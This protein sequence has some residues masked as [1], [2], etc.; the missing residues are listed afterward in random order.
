MDAHWTEKQPIVPAG[1]CPLPFVQVGMVVRFAGHQ[2]SDGG[3]V[4]DVY[5]DDLGM[6]CARLQGRIT[7]RSIVV[8]C[9]EV[10]RCYVLLADFDPNLPDD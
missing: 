4:Q 8:S 7:G 9:A 10:R 3:L 6:T 2:E 5:E 1:T